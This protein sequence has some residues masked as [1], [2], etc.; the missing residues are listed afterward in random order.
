MWWIVALI[1]IAV[2]IIAIV[3]PKFGRALL[4]IILVFG[5]ISAVIFLLWFLY[6]QHE[7][8][9]SKKRIPISE[10]QIDDLLLTPVPYRPN[11][12]YLS[13][14]LKNKSQ[15]FSLQSI[16]IKI[17]MRD[18]IKPDECEIVGEDTALS[19]LSIPPGQVRE[20]NGMVLFSYLA[21][22]KGKNQWDYSVVEL[23]GK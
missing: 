23:K 2:V 12:Y 3:F 20:M 5:A 6:D 10:I 17:T 13:G 1:V 11:E 9:L 22:P 7:D 16:K 15:H 8:E 19:S 18:C 4:K 14:R 21:K